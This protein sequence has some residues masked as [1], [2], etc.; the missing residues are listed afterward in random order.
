MHKDWKQIAGELTGLMAETRKGVPAVGKA[1]GELATAATAAGALDTKT[2]E[3]VAVAISVAARCDG[4][5]AFHV[6]AAVRQGATREELLETVGMAIY[7]G[8]G[9]AMVYGAQAMEAFE[10]FS[11]G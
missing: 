10:Q 2:K 3:L 8:G 9:P 6:R 5:I 7:M 1:F 4:C 11:A